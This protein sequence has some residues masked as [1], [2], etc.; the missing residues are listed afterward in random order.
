MRNL[1]NNLARGGD[2]LSKLWWLVAGHIDHLCANQVETAVFL[3]ERKQ[4]PLE[5]RRDVLTDDYTYQRAFIDLIP[6]GQAAGQIRSDV[7]PKLAALSILGSANW[8][9]SWYRPGGDLAPETIGRQF[10]TM[11]VN[12]LATEEALRSWRLTDPPTVAPAQE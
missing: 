3:H 1:R 8:V 9:Y 10:A 2:P 11:T 7:D 12:S 5:R 4:I 6:E